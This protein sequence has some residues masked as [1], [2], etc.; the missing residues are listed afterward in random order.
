MKWFKEMMKRRERV[1]RD[2]GCTYPKP[3]S[4]VEP[5]FCRTRWRHRTLVQM[6]SL[7]S[8]LAIGSLYRLFTLKA[9]NS[10][11]GFCWTRWRHRTLKERKGGE[12]ERDGSDVVVEKKRE[13]R[14]SK[15]ERER[16]R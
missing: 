9:S 12:S 5:R 10:K 3:M 7:I 2:E 14:K 6:C 16:E 13:K 4:W 8:S 11:L 1:E 15:R